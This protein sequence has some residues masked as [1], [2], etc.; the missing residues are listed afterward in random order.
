[1]IKF[2]LSGDS[3]YTTG[4]IQY[5]SDSSF[6]V[7]ETNILIKDIETIDLNPQINSSSIFSGASGKVII[8]GLFLPVIDLINQGDPPTPAIWTVSGSIV[9]AGFLLKLIENRKFYPARKNCSISIIE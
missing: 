4:R 7:Y 8:A 1:L 2:K 5:I 9:L 6:K 3:Y